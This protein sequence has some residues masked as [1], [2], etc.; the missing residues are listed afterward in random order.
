MSDISKTKVEE[1]KIVEKENLSTN[2]HSQSNGKSA[3]EGG[4]STSKLANQNDQSSEAGDTKKKL[5]GNLISNQFLEDEYILEGIMDFF[6]FREIFVYFY[7][8]NKTV[9][10][11]VKEANYLLLRKLADYF[12]ITS[13]YLTSELPANEDML[14]VYQQAQIDMNNERDL[15]LKPQAFY[16]DSGLVGTNMWYSF[17][18]IFDTNNSNM[19]GGYIFSTNSGTNNHIQ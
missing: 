4:H 7:P 10:R 3:E 18:N 1:E 17:H 2:I 16:T 19:Y 14:D 9:Q 13:G 6:T 15:D 5:S 12:N 8:L 11:L